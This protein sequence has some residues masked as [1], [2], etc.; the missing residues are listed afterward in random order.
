[1]LEILLEIPDE[2][3]GTILHAVA[4]GFHPSID[5]LLVI[6]RVLADQMVK[7]RRLQRSLAITR[8]TLRRS[9]DF[10]FLYEGLDFENV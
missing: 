5:L 1:M 6:E 3:G 4:P 10:F 2:N 7:A 9:A 8:F